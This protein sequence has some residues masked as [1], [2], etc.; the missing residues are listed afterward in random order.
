[1][2]DEL[3]I[4]TELASTAPDIVRATVLMARYA[5]AKVAQKVLN[6]TADVKGPGDR[7]SITVMPAFTV[8]SVTNASGAVATKESSTVTSVE[9]IV[10]LWKYVRWDVVDLSQLQSAIDPYRAWLEGAGGALGEDQDANLLGEQSNLTSYTD[11]GGS[12]PLDDK[13]IRK[14]RLLLDRANIPEEDRFF[15][16]HPDGES[17]LLALPRFTEAQ[18]TGFGRGVQVSN[19]HISGLYGHPVVVTSLVKETS[20]LK[21][22]VLLHKEALAIATQKNFTIVPLA[23]IQL[24]KDT[25]AHILYGV[26]TVRASHGVV[27]SSAPNA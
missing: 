5:R 9:V 8:Q 25:V 24:S 19:G 12:V 16:L 4:G 17:D 20:S 3:D 6:A 13:I 23:K 21:R 1:M 14:G 2:A 11:P 10:N 7:V 18:N 15:V 26:K 27:L 22:N